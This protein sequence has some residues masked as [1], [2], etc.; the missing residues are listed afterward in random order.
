MAMDMWYTSSAISV[1]S[2]TSS[3]NSVISYHCCLGNCSLAWHQLPVHL[4]KW[5]IRLRPSWCPHHVTTGL[6][7]QGWWLY[8]GYGL[9]DDARVTEDY[10]SSENKSWD[11][12]K[13]SQMQGINRSQSM[14]E[15]FVLHGELNPGDSYSIIR[16]QM[17]KVER[18][19]DMHKIIDKNFP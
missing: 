10:R 16:F 19:E 1:V 17:E 3:V 14:K 6:T 8:L 2:N 13:L 7:T 5:E 11:T 18:I 4:L 15:T 9:E 12:T